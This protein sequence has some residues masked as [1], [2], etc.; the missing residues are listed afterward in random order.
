MHREHRENKLIS[1][2]LCVHYKLLIA[3]H[4]AM[5]SILEK[6]DIEIDMNPYPLV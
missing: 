4:N 2:E 5:K 6:R 3:I 1:S